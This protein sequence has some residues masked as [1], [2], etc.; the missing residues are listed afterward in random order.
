MYPCNTCENSNDECVCKK[1]KFYFKDLFIFLKFFLVCLDDVNRYDA[2]N[3][4]CL[5]GYFKNST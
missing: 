1:K 3:C 5:P 2:P 4:N